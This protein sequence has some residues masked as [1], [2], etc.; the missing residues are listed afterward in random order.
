MTTAL[1]ER[2][3][4]ALHGAAW[5]HPTARDLNIGI[6]NFRHMTEGNAP[7]PPGVWADL[8]KLLVAHSL[9]CGDLAAELPRPW[10]VKVVLP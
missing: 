3:G 1:L 9:A 2:A 8:R 7:I 10:P 4:V 6:R 5:K